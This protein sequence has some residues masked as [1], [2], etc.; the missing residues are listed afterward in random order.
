MASCCRSPSYQEYCPFGAFSCIVFSFP[1]VA[2][3]REGLRVA[4]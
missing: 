3:A 2:P 1:V 4:G